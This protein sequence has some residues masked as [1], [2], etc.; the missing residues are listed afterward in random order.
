MMYQNKYQILYNNETISGKIIKTQW[1]EIRNTIMHLYHKHK[2]N[3]KYGNI[4]WKSFI[5]ACKNA[6]PKKGI[7]KMVH[8]IAPT[9]LTLYKPQMSHDTLCPICRENKESIIH[10]FKCNESNGLYCQ[11]FC[12]L[13]NKKLKGKS[14]NIKISLMI[15]TNQ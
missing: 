3:K 1:Q 2:F 10:I 8:N 4:L 7:L 15:S 5:F 12:K 9:Q 13:L 6:N 11:N 14:M